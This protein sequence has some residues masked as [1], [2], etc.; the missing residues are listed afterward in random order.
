MVDVLRNMASKIR[1]SASQA[2]D[3]IRQSSY[4]KT[5][6][7]PICLDS[8]QFQ[9]AAPLPRGPRVTVALWSTE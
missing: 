4:V 6:F 8:S 9:A 3:T 5:D 1:L 2:L 7:C